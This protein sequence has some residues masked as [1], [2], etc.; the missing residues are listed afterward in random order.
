MEPYDPC[1]PRALVLP[2][3]FGDDPD[4]VELQIVITQ[5]ES[6]HYK[7]TIVMQQKSKEFAREVRKKAARI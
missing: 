6:C 1:T 5:F 7:N 3:G 4:D 2:V